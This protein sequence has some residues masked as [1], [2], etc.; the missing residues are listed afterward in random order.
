VRLSLPQ[1][2]PGCYARERTSTEVDLR[3]VNTVRRMVQDRTH[4]YGV[5]RGDDGAG[6]EG[7]T[8]LQLVA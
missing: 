6:P 5:D 8:R 3:A 2:L 1:P 7:G 4:F